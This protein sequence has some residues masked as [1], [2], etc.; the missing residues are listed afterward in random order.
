MKT[1][2][3]KYTYSHSLFRVKKMNGRPKNENLAEKQ[4]LI[5]FTK[6]QYT[7]LKKIS[8]QN[9]TSIAAIVR[10]AVA[11]YLERKT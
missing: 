11:Q 9:D 3:Y 7:T 4:L 10:Q 2:I 8:A 1:V 5:R 6:K